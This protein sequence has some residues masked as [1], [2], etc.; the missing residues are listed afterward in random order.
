MK[1][2]IATR[3]ILFSSLKG[4]KT[5]FFA[6]DFLSVSCSSFYEGVR[7]DRFQTLAKRNA[8]LFKQLTQVLP[9]PR[10]VGVAGWMKVIVTSVKL[11][12]AQR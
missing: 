1:K 9:A 8:S 7:V 6:L 10:L 11:T 4:P 2:S 3:L 12:V 5:K